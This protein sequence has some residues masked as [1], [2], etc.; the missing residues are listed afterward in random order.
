[1]AAVAATRLKA[2][3][4]DGRA[5]GGGKK[6]ST[7][8]SRIGVAEW[9]GPRKPSAC[10]ST[11]KEN[12]RSLVRMSSC[13]FERRTSDRRKRRAWIHPRFVEARIRG[14]RYPSNARSCALFNH[15]G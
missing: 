9:R 14:S 3:P 11:R 10:P 2:Y 12:C 4:R 13:V 6:R 15:D 5:W 8:S 7:L 1:T